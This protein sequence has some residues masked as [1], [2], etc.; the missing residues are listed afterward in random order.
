MMYTEEYINDKWI[1]NDLKI[2][3]DEQNPKK[4]GSKTYDKYEKYKYSKT[5][6]EFKKNKGWKEDFKSAINS[7]CLKFISNNDIIETNSDKSLSYDIVDDDNNDNNNN[8]DCLNIIENIII[9]ELDKQNY[10]NLINTVN[11]DILKS[12][13]KCS[14]GIILE[15]LL[16]A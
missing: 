3:I 9:T 6:G 15:Y 5:I 8:N 7:G 11:T 10:I 1:N 4:P 14:T 16:N 12:L 13:K 2:C